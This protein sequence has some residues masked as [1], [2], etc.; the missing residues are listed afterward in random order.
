MGYWICIENIV[1]KIRGFLN[2]QNRDDWVWGFLKK[3]SS[4]ASV[5]TSARERVIKARQQ[6][7]RGGGGATGS[8]PGEAPRPAAAAAGGPGRGGQDVSLRDTHPPLAPRERAFRAQAVPAA[9]GSLQQE[10]AAGRAA[11]ARA[12]SPRV[13]PRHASARGGGV[14][15]GWGLLPPQRRPAP[16]CVPGPRRQKGTAGPRREQGCSA[17]KRSPPGGGVGGG[18]AAGAAPLPRAPAEGSGETGKAER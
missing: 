14:G 15:V 7:S 11:P 9:A 8:R 4:D 17:G 18:G 2:G 16:G 5:V 6:V 1:G 10:H 13:S 12:H 3:E